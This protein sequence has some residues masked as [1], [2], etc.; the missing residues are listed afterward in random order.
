MNI[1]AIL[2]L[3]CVQNYTECTSEKDFNLKVSEK[4]HKKDTLTNFK[5]YC[6]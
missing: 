4:V 5:H 6:H 2:D 3:Y 1:V